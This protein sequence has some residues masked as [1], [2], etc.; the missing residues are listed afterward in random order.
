MHLEAYFCTSSYTVRNINWHTLGIEINSLSCFAYLTHFYPPSDHR[1]HEELFWNTER[2]S[3]SFQTAMSLFIAFLSFHGLFFLTNKFPASFLPHT[4][5]SFT[6]QSP[7]LTDYYDTNSTLFLNTSLCICQWKN[8]TTNI[9]D[10]AYFLK[11][12]ALHNSD[13][14]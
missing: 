4:V 3:T 8:I 7:L 6:N 13:S 5:F 12:L 1:G 11:E 2:R 10:K 9:D 14:S